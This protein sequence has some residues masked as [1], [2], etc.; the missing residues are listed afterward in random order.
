MDSAAFMSSEKKSK[1]AL[2]VKT[3]LLEYSLIL[4]DIEKSRLQSEFVTL[5]DAEKAARTAEDKKRV[6]AEFDLATA[7]GRWDFD[8]KIPGNF[9]YCD[10]EEFV[11]RI[12]SEETHSVRA[13]TQDHGLSTISFCMKPFCGRGGMKEGF[14]IL[15]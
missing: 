15:C 2:A 12:E 11:N 5:Y 1:T 10:I 3:F 14:T 4:T 6:S 8:W 9:S 7:A 13:F